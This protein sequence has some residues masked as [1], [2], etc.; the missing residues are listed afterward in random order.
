MLLWCWCLA[1]HPSQSNFNRSVVSKDFHA[2]E[3]R[4]CETRYRWIYQKSNETDLNCERKPE[5]FWWGYINT[6]CVFFPRVFVVVVVCLLFENRVFKF[7]HN[8]FVPFYY[9]SVLYTWWFKEKNWAFRNC[10]VLVKHRYM[11]TDES[12]YE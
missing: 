6:V 11:R 7:I 10:I 8:G 5:V 4:K 12:P 9:L 3:S 1:C 2:C